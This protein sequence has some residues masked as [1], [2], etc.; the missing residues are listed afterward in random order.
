[1]EMMATYY[2]SIAPLK[3]A[4]VTLSFVAGAVAVADYFL[5]FASNFVYWKVMD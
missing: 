1:M 4:V 2:Y 5:N 3:M